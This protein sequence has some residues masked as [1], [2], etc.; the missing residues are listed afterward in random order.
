MRPT[1]LP[2]LLLL[3]SGTAT[4]QLDLPKKKVER[5]PMRPRRSKGLDLPSRQVGDL[6]PKPGG[7]ENELSIPVQPA[8]VFLEPAA[9]DS[10]PGAAA[11]FIFD[12]L[13]QVENP[14]SSIALG[15]VA[16]L[17]ALGSEG[18]AA[19]RIALWERGGV[20][21]ITAA[22]V[23]VRFG[24]VEERRVVVMRLEERVPSR[25]A[26]PLLATVLAAD[27]VLA[28][29]EL[30][31]GLLDHPTSAMRT[32]AQRALSGRVDASSLTLLAVHLG[33]K[34]AHTRQL[35]LSLI[36]DVDDPSVRLLIASRLGDATAKVA[37]RAA[38]LL[39]GLEDEAVTGML[40]ENV[41]GP[42]DLDREGA[43]ALLALI[44]REDRRRVPLLGEQHIDALLASMRNVDIEV[45]AGA[46]AAALAGI[47][48]R[49]EAG[50]GGT[51]LDREV[52]HTLVRVS[53]G[54]VFHADF[55]ALQP[56]ALARLALITGQ[57][58]G[59]N[60][61]AWQTWWANHADGFRARRAFLAVRP[62]EAT[63]LRVTYAGDL[64]REEVWTLV[65]TARGADVADEQAVYLTPRQCDRLLGT[66]RESGVLGAERM[67]QRLVGTGIAGRSLEIGV[68]DESKHFEVAFSAEAPWF[69]QVE[70]VVLD[71]VAENRWQSF[72]EASVPRY[73]FWL[74]ENEWWE[75]ETSATARGRRLKD[76]VLK[77]LSSTQP[78][79]R[80]ADVAELARVYAE[81]GV[82]EPVDFS[83]LLDLLAD[84]EYFAGRA[85]KV[86]DLALICAATT[87]SPSRPEGATIEPELGRA[88]FEVV[89]VRFGESARVAAERVLIAC[90]R[91]VLR[92][93]AAAP[94]SFR[95]GLAPRG[96][97]DGAQAADLELL[98]A[99]LDDPVPE[100]EVAAIQALGEAR[101]AVARDPIFQRARTGQ[102]VVRAAALRAAGRLGGDEVMN[103][104]ILGLAEKDR[105]VQHAAALALAA[106]ADPES[107]ALLASLFARGPES[108]F[109]EPAR[110][111]LLSLGA[112][113]RPELMRLTTAGATATRRE[114]AL[115]LARQGAPEACSTLFTLLTQQPDDDRVA[116]ELA[117]LT[118]VDFRG[119][120]NPVVA[121]WAWWDLVVHDDSLAWLRA[122]GVR[123][124]LEPPTTGAIESEGTR[125]G[126]LFLATMMQLDRPHLVERARR[127]LERLLGVALQAPP[128]AG[129]PRTQWL[130]EIRQQIDESY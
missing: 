109:F 128:A 67:P 5:T 59:R 8:P 43:Y 54:A 16:S 84:E 127:E 13:D 120:E 88:L 17:G 99:L 63:L 123:E 35:A 92:E 20:G 117:V 19:S 50:V 26:T 100:V 32:A 78:W 118:C 103:L 124:G 33:S 47:G 27:P 69:E 129:Q 6:A 68:R 72:H 66:L 106:L 96:L 56:T 30:L 105:E 21:V 49:S 48:F 3:L 64:R 116:A 45:V 112:A 98:L 126:A 42:G 11:S 87:G 22:R 74:A 95:R 38:D 113:A 77:R 7:K 90:G 130:A 2:C 97:V 44:Q 82:P 29:P 39:A 104:C 51:W 101:V 114:A 119:E 28:T 40:L 57:N 37:I 83:Q 93:M 46:S 85:Q 80:D 23:L 25:I 41:F 94:Q 107:A 14:D 12:Q 79:N 15:A 34:R 108:H 115:L 24:G 81:P 53:S 31:I 122:A 60:G 1:I 65:G 62:E 10:T 71:L 111:G 18:L 89:T 73:E 110:Q 125:E 58:F 76:L 55:S 4:A 61:P 91:A 9:Y 70:R 86:F 121:W 36:T 102:P 75:N 52:P